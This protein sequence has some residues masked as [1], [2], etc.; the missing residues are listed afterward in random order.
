MNILTPPKNYILFRCAMHDCRPEEYLSKRNK[1][2]NSNGGVEE[3]KAF[4]NELQTARHNRTLPIE[5]IEIREMDHRKHGKVVRMMIYDIDYF[6]RDGKILQTKWYQPEECL[7]NSAIWG[8]SY[9][10]FNDPKGNKNIKKIDERIKPED[11]EILRE[12]AKDKFKELGDEV[13]F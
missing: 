1:F 2:F 8:T 12:K 13:P 11:F 4:C 9:S 5:S 10:F 3:I 6:L 7:Y